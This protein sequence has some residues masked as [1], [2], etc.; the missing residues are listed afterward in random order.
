M[1]LRLL[2]S[3][4]AQ[5]HDFA[6]A[7]AVAARKPKKKNNNFASKINIS[8]RES[9]NSKMELFYQQTEKAEMPM[10]KKRQLFACAAAKLRPPALVRSILTR[11]WH[12]E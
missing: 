11:F 6:I 2:R 7:A 12:T 5:L 10:H 9:E 3:W 4:R 8:K 1:L